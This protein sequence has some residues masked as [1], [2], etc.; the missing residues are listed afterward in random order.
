MNELVDLRIDQIVSF[1]DIGGSIIDTLP[2]EYSPL[3]NLISA[4]IPEINRA[5]QAF[6]KSQ[7]A[8]MN[9]NMTVSYVSPLRNLRQIL[10]E[11][12]RTFEAL[13]ESFFKI[14]KLE[15][16]I[17][18]AD[19]DY[20]LEADE[21]KRKLILID[22]AEKRSNLDASRDYVAGA[23]RKVAGYV[24]TY[25]QIKESKGIG[26]WTEK[27]FEEQ[28]EMYHITRAFQQG[29]C[30]ARSHGGVIDEGN[31]IYLQNIG[32]N[33]L[34]AQRDVTNYFKWEDEC[35]KVGINIE[36]T[37]EWDFFIKMSVKYKGCSSKV[38]KF[39]GM[40]PDIDSIAIV[41]NF[42]QIL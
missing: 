9:N 36:P 8:F 31:F 20:T 19:R 26:N 40:D 13:R 27:D 33:G 32:V 2:M 42:N 21:L 7:S 29:I 16:E 12:N 41:D 39:K 23:V 11:I 28:E 6:Y 37:A 25:N 5:T 30:A 34:S 35:L 24:E 38:A 15:V 14:K 17:E 22:I 3:V 1:K 18:I 4:N 10:S